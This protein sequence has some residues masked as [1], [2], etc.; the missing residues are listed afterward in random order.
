MTRVPASGS[1]S[2]RSTPGLSRFPMPMPSS[3]LCVS[4]GST[5]LSNGWTRIVTSRSL[6]RESPAAI[7]RISIASVMPTSNQR[8]CFHRR[9]SDDHLPITATPNGPRSLA[10]PSYIEKAFKANPKAWKFFRQL[11]P[12]YRR[13][14]VG[15]IAT[16]K[17]PETR[18]NRIRK[19]IRVLAAE[20]SWV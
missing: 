12:P 19:A 8:V 4:D 11:A 5:A 7:G 10:V 18:E 2:T 9:E 17:R 14:Y 13:S 3:K 16:A 1:R 20:T 6:R 15:W